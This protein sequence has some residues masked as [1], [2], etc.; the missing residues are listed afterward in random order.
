MLFAPPCANRA[1]LP[2]PVWPPQFFGASAHDKVLVHVKIKYLLKKQ[3]ILSDFKPRSWFKIV[4]KESCF[5]AI[6][7]NSLIHQSLSDGKPANCY[8]NFSSHMLKI[9][10]SSSHVA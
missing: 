5:L 6:Q 7:S 3:V 8:S 2:H 4:S 1:A 9:R 10:F